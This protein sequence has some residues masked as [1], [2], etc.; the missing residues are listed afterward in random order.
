MLTTEEFLRLQKLAAISLSQQET[1]K[2]G[3]Q[4]S[5][6]VD[7]L[8][9]LK[10]ISYTWDVHSTTH[11]LQTISWSHQYQ[12]VQDLFINTKHEKVGNSIVVNSVIDN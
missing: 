5:T 10:N 6:I 9:K 4:L 1:E 2:L 12:N 7:F 3:N 11:S 8:G